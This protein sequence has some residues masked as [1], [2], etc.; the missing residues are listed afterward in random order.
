MRYLFLIFCFFNIATASFANPNNISYEDWLNKKTKRIILHAHN[1]NPMVLK[2]S[3]AAHSQAQYRGLHNKSLLTIIDY[4]RP[5][6]ARRLWVI[7]LRKEKVLFNTWVS[8]GR[9][10]GTANA[11]H[12]SNR[13]NSLQ[14]SLGVFIT[15]EAYTG[16]LGYALRLQGLE[17][18]INDNAYNRSIVFHGAW[19]ANPYI[20]KRYGM[21]G[22]SW[23][24][25]AV[26]KE[27]IRPLVDT[28]KNR[29]LVV[30]YY[31]NRQWLKTSAFLQTR[32]FES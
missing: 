31:P 23:G 30:A 29:T 13:M 25:M 32:R 7:D 2:L 16:H 21:L 20:A 10:S 11:V 15:Q 18:G 9:N 4:S 14:S 19:Y 3:I 6:S 24:C 8:H 26:S 5:S 1:L 17:H 22:R 12:F 27:I 28:I